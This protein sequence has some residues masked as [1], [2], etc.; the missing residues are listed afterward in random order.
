VTIFTAAIFIVRL[1]VSFL[2]YAAP[3]GRKS[4]RKKNKA[5]QQGRKFF[6][7][8]QFI[9]AIQKY[10]LHHT[11]FEYSM[12]MNLPRDEIFYL[13]QQYYTFRTN[14]ETLKSEFLLTFEENQDFLFSVEN[15]GQIVMVYESLDPLPLLS[16]DLKNKILSSASTST[17]EEENNDSSSGNLLSIERIAHWL[18]SQFFIKQIVVQIGSLHGL[19]WKLDVLQNM[20]NNDSNLFSISEYGKY[21]LLFYLLFCL[22]SHSI[23]LF[24]IL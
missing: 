19:I 16:G 17:S 22:Y 24:R 9:H 12:R 13:E 18:R 20:M 1:I 5:E 21:S 23:A 15:V 8:T 14:A 10:M 4:K 11:V 6:L 3:V 7:S 2:S